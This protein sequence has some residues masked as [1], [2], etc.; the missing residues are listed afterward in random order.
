MARILVAASPEPRAILE[1]MLAG[2]ELCCA[3]T[4]VQA[5][6]LLRRRTFDLIVCTI[7]FDESKMFDL[8][9]LAKS[10]PPW[11]RIPFVA[12]RVRPQILRSATARRDTAFTCA[13]LGAE[14][15]LDIADYETN[16]EREMREAI[17][18]FLS[19]DRASPSDAPRS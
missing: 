4:L 18:R 14:G 3:E 11:R 16:P 8:L 10:R 2:H 9:Q 15:F 12:S 19:I 5:E 17:E 6:Q 1:R 7:A 13:A